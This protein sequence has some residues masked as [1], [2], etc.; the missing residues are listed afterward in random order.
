MLL[1]QA[2]LD[3]IIL[4]GIIMKYGFIYETT[5]LI[6]GMKYIGKH[7]RK[8]Y[9]EDPDD[10]WYLGSGLHIIRAVEKYGSSNFSR[11]ILCDCDSEEELQEK[12]RYYIDL[13]DAVN[14]PNYYNICRD[15]NPPINDRFGIHPTN[16]TRKNQ[17]IAAQNRRVSRTCK[18]CQKEFISKSGRAIYCS[19][20]C[21]AIDHPKIIKEKKQYTI[22][23][24]ERLRRS[25]RAKGNKNS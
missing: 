16:E 12:E 1:H 17:S 23:D 13:Y 5:N 22:T 25:E 11:R 9:N 18:V 6:T 15:A 8:K 19:D 10:S 2:H 4:G 20:E 14:S 3:Y 24:E 21:Y 7:K